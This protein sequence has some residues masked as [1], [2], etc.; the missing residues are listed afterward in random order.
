[1]VSDLQQTLLALHPL[2][3]VYMRRYYCKMISKFEPPPPPPNHV[4][5]EPIMVNKYC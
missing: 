5:I 4:D 3:I 2:L 1:M